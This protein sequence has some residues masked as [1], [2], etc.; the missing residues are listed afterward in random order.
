MTSEF[1]IELTNGMLW[2]A[3]LI[4][5]PVLGLSM[6]VGLLVSILQVVTQVQDIS[7]TFVPKMLTVGLALVAF[8][9]WMLNVLVEF[10]RSSIAGIPFY[11]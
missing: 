4:A 1:A 11:F 9:S 6:A 2:T 8:G 5:L 7:I 10:A 3:M